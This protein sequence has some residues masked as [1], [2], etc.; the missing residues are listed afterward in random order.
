MCI[1]ETSDADLNGILLVEHVAFDSGKEVELTRDLLADP[2]AKPFLSLMAFI[3]GQPV[4]HILF[5]AA[6]LVNSEI[7]V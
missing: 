4:G 2:T 5:T 3:R 6:H 7:A 1:Q